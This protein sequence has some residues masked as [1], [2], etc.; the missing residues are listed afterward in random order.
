MQTLILLEKMDKE[1]TTEKNIEIC[2]RKI[3]GTEIEKCY[4]YSIDIH[5]VIRDRIN[6]INHN[7]NKR[8]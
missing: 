5:N 8:C 1:K 4:S 3:R 6:Y 7:E 2:N